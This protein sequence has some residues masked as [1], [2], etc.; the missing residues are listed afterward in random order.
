MSAPNGINGIE[1]VI[2]GVEDMATCTR[3]FDD[4][5]LPLVEASDAEALFELT[6]RLLDHLAAIG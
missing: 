6:A 4:F 2:Y 1:T 3:Y 5:G